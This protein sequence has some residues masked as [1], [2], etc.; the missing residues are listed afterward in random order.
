MISY[1]NNLPANAS[2]CFYIT[3]HGT[4]AHTGTHTGTHTHTYTWE[5]MHA[6]A[7]THALVHTHSERER[8]T[9]TS[10]D[11]I[12]ICLLLSI[13]NIIANMLMYYETIR[14]CGFVMNSE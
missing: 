9:Y 10:T 7:H 4:Y 5:Y 12:R 1:S 6:Q 11:I 2:L 3:P 8:H 13:I 14:L